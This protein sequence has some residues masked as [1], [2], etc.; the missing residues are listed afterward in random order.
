MPRLRLKYNLY[1]MLKI[2]AFYRTLEDLEKADEIYRSLTFILNKLHLKGPNGKENLSQNFKDA[3]AVSCI[4]DIAEDLA[5]SQVTFV[6]RMKT[7]WSALLNKQRQ[8]TDT[9][10]NYSVPSEYYQG[11]IFGGVYYV[12]SKQKAVTDE[13]LGFIETFVSDFPEA[14]PY[15][16]V[17][18]NE[19]IGDTHP[20]SE[21]QS[22][23]TH[24]IPAD[25]TDEEK[26]ER[27]NSNLEVEQLRKAL[28]KAEDE[29]KEM[30]KTIESLRDN[31]QAFGVRS[32]KG[33]KLPL[34]TAKQVAIFLKAIFFEHNSLTNNAKNLT[35]LLQR[36][37]GWAPTT[38]ENALGYEVTQDECDELAEIFQDYAPKI[39]N[40]IKAYPG[41]FKQQKNEKLQNNLKS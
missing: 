21:S 3:K 31:I 14:L 13:H 6:S 24:D 11:V 34:L 9:F 20:S 26:V 32:K 8:F 23:P 1:N 30:T 15:F 29:K 22:T 25:E 2:K 37:G 28:T 17:F 18:K 38:A 16:N 7:L 10:E 5:K 27:V 35:P 4:R 36:F 12:L 33:D 40:I 19:T 39:G 41:K